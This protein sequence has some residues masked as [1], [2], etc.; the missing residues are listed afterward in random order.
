MMFLTDSN[1]GLTVCV[2]VWCLHQLHAGSCWGIWKGPVSGFRRG[3][4]CD[5]PGRDPGELSSITAAKFPFTRASA[6][7]K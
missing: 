7:R 6:L 3:L 4:G 2:P 1:P 5:A